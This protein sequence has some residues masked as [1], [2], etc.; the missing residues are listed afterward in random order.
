[1][2]KLL[3]R[4]GLEPVWAPEGNG[5]GNG[6]QQS[7]DGT[8]DGGAGDGG[9]ASGGDGGGSGGGDGGDGKPPA[10]SRTSKLGGLFGQRSNGSSGESGDDDTGDGNGD[11]ADDGRP[12]GLADKFWDATKKEIRVDALITAQR[13]AEKALGDL[14]RSK[15]I[16]GEVPEDPADYFRGGVELPEELDARLLP[17]DDPGLGVAANVFKKH[18]IGKDIAAA[19]V[20]DMFAG[21]SEH[22]QPPIDPAQEKAALGKGADQLIDGLFTWVEG[23]ERAGDISSDDIDVIEGMMMT[24]KGA[25]LL[26]KFRNMTGEKPIPLAPGNGGVSGMSQAEWHDAMKEA[27]KAKDYKRQAELEAMGEM[28]NGTEPGISG[29]QGGI[30]V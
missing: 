24:A 13:D 4:Y 16:G 19:I 20:K 10:S 11:V 6:G 8:G 30:N 29:R 7:E 14:R 15:T 25:K 27:V 1:M 3:K 5:G 23:M 28:I 2:H 12:K 21:M 17:P 26:A 22:L 9:D 18:G